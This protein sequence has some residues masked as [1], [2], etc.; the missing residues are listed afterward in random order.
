MKLVS[1]P[2]K[3]NK[4]PARHSKRLAPTPRRV[5]KDHQKQFPLVL[6]T[7]NDRLPSDSS[8]AAHRAKTKR[9][10][11]W[12]FPTNQGTGCDQS[13]PTSSGLTVKEVR[14]H[15]LRKQSWISKSTGYWQEKAQGRFIWLVQS[16]R[17]KVF[18]LSASKLQSTMTML[19]IGQVARSSFLKMEAST[20]K[21]LI[22]LQR[23]SVR[24]S[25]SLRPSKRACFAC[26]PL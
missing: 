25:T 16:I 1:A 3:L 20:A 10:P 15:F 24:R 14:S 26:S 11:C 12:S 8:A 17:P 5:R 7:G 21:S 4:R 6:V 22:D 2:R 19:T 23:L 9:P 13:T 18:R